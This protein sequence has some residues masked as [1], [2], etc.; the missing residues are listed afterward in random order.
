MRN[1]GRQSFG[2]FPKGE[3]H[4]FA[5]L[6]IAKANAIRSRYKRG[7]IRMKDLAKEYGVSITTVD[8]IL[9]RKIWNY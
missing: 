2:R 3:Q 7:V 1:K 4:Y 5:K 6:T 8:Y 9:K